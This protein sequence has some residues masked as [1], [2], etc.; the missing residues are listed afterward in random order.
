M[1]SNHYCIRGVTSQRV[2]SVGVISADN[3]AP[4]KRRGGGD[5]VT[6]L[7]SPRI[8]TQT[9][10]ANSNIFYHYDDEPVKQTLLI[11]QVDYRL[12]R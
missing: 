5:I 9:S 2:A 6:D 11:K 7:T 12:L 4:S 3:T 8:E 10:H 1:I